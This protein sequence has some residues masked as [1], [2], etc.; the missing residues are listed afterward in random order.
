MGRSVKEFWEEQAETYRSSDLA[1]APDHHYRTLEIQRIFDRL[2]DGEQVLDVGCGNGY[3]TAYFA[4]RCP[5]SSF[6]G[7]DY[8][9]EM[10]ANAPAGER[11]EFA[12]GDVLALDDCAALKGRLFDT[13][14][15][16]RLLINLDSWPTQQQAILNLKA[17]LKPGGRLLLVEN[18]RDGLSRLNN[19]R[20]AQGIHRIE[21]R[22]HNVYLPERELDDFLTEHFSIEHRENIGNLYY[23]LSRVVYARLAAD[24]G[25]EPDYNHRIN[26]I[27]ASLPH[28]PGDW[29]PN[30]LYVLREKSVDDA[31]AED[32]ASSDAAMRILD[33]MAADRSS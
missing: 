11:L 18:T 3:S 19:L 10:I 26:E 17:L 24:E 25:V 23:I 21:T 8:S 16:C 33:D 13:V 27:A 2:S 22:W 29:S 32:Q 15:C 9:A 31:L 20:E 1:T 7:V 14:I 28:V 4:A 5:N 6:V 30:W 12:I